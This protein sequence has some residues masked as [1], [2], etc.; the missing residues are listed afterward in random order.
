MRVCLTKVKN[1]GCGCNEFNLSICADGHIGRQLRKNLPKSICGD[2]VKINFIVSNCDGILP[3][4]ALPCN[5]LLAVSTPIRVI[6]RNPCCNNN[7]INNFSNDLNNFSNN[8]NLEGLEGEDSSINDFNINDFNIDDFRINDISSTGCNNRLANNDFNLGLDNENKNC[9]FRESF[10]PQEFVIIVRSFST[11]L[12]KFFCK[13]PQMFLKD[14]DNTIKLTIIFD[15]K[16]SVDPN[17]NFN[18]CCGGCGDFGCGGFGGCCGFG[19]GGCGGFGC[20][21]GCGGWFG[22]TALALLFCCC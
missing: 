6:R 12:S 20:G 15:R 13:F 1:N 3:A 21:C 17:E 10:E 8:F 11:W 22:L 14:C 9:C 2:G 4:P 16:G 7:S 19:C 18:N 5:D